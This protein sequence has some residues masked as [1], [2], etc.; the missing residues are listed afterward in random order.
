MK[1]KTSE[2]EGAALDWA[3]AQSSKAWEFGHS[4][5]PAM[6]LDPTFKSV[7][8][9]PYPRGEFGA[10]VDTCVLLPRNSMRQ[11][12]LPFCPSSDWSHCGPIIE[13]MD[14]QVRINDW[15]NEVKWLGIARSADRMVMVC[16][17]GTTPLI[18][19]CRAIV[20]AKLGDDVDVPEDLI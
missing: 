6:T 10:L 20:A 4:L 17:K 16:Q 11:D 5:H 14:V 13:K 15:P 12:P 9:R 8:I 19:A 7:C 3:V 18:A 2:L 1:I